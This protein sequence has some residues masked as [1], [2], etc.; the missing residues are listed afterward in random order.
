MTE[1]YVSENNKDCV[2]VDKNGNGLQR[3]WQQHITSFQNASLETAEAVMS[4]FPTLKSLFQVFT[5]IIKYFNKH[6]I[7]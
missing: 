3:L 4:R 1:C 6:K 7:K 5:I 2:R